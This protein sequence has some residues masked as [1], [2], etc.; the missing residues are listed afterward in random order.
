MFICNRVFKSIIE[1]RLL[2]GV[3]SKEVT[4]VSN[5]KDYLLA[6]E[7]NVP[8]LFA[9]AQGNKILPEKLMVRTSKALFLRIIFLICSPSVLLAQTPTTITGL[10]V[11]P[12]DVVGG[13]ATVVRGTVTIQR[14]TDGAGNILNGPVGFQVPEGPGI[15]QYD[16]LICDFPIAAAGGGFNCSVPMNATSAGFTFAPDAPPVDLSVPVEVHLPVSGELQPGQFA[17]TPITIRA[18]QIILKLTPSI[19]TAGTTTKVTATLS[20]FGPPAPNQEDD[21]L[22]QFNP[23]FN[24]FNVFS[25]KLEALGN[26]SGVTFSTDFTDLSLLGIPPFTF[27]Q[28]P[29]GPKE[30]S[31]QF[32]ITAQP[33]VL[34][35]PFRASLNLVEFNR[36]GRLTANATLNVSHTKAQ[37]EALLVTPGKDDEFITAS[38]PNAQEAHFPLGSAFQINLWMPQP[39]GS[40]IGI[41]A[42][43]TLDQTPTFIHILG[44]NPMFPK[45]VVFPYLPQL[46]SSGL[47][48]QT[49][50]QGSQKLTITP[51]DSN[52]PPLTVTLVV[53]PP[54]SL[55]STHNDLDAG[56]ITV[57]DSTGVPPQMIKGQV[58]AEGQFNPF[59]FRY[60]P[61]NNQVGDLAIS[62]GNDLRIQNPYAH[63]RLPT[64][65]DSLDPGNCNPFPD[66]DLGIPD[67]HCPGL[68]IGNSFSQHEMDVITGSE[69]T[70]HLRTWER[71][72]QTGQLVLANNQRVPRQLAAVDRYISARDVFEA[73]DRVFH[74]STYA[75]ANRI[76]QLGFSGEFPLAGSYGLLQMTYFT[77][78]S[79]LQWQ[80][81]NPPCDG[82]SDPLDPTGLYDTACN[83]LNGGGSLGLGTTKVK[84]A[85]ISDNGD[86][87]SLDGVA[88]FF[89]SLEGAYQSYNRAKT[90]YGEGVVSGS[91][92]FPPMSSRAIFNSGGQ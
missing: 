26:T 84:N 6:H 52:I 14:G 39:D 10:S 9:E 62:R 32:T 21:S 1:H 90:G 82:A 44:A 87:P 65:G 80:G 73:S 49:V 4:F 35:V 7:M 91:Q 63:L 37:L 34:Q 61:L 27:I 33:G 40:R 3:R 75:P 19:I 81:S 41:P 78:I 22:P 88:S 30:F 54:Q 31:K 36:I 67:P 60:E 92:H 50:H 47:V 18:Q 43:F 46:L 79:E 20:F 56:I 64:I 28:G 57:A 89:D 68:D 77:A 15:I 25:A 51:N 69:Q 16:G 2:S 42:T 70:Y 23:V 53:D 83:L 29:A 76:S 66:V 58:E 12:S 8:L 48:F 59:T 72:P 71:N 86:T 45:N 11:T 17:T 5:T 13:S 74:F 85:F 38:D 24:F 55:G